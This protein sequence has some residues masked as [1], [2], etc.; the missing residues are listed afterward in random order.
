[1]RGVGVGFVGVDCEREKVGC[2]SN[3]ECGSGCGGDQRQWKVVAMR[4]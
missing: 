1:M 3:D 4:R 2:I